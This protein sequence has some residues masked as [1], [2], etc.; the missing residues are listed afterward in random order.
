MSLMATITGRPA[1]TAVWLRNGIVM[2]EVEPDTAGKPRVCV[3]SLAHGDAARHEH[4]R[5][6][7]EGP[8]WESGGRFADDYYSQGPSD[9]CRGVPVF[10]SL[11]WSGRR[12]VSIGSKVRAPSHARF[13]IPDSTVATER[14]ESPN[15]GKL[16]PPQN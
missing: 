3:E 9:A 12:H 15:S 11:P 16:V 1:V 5:G 2:G 14:R 7:D 13:G 8:C 6:S 4:H 10:L